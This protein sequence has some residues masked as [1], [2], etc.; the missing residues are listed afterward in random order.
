MYISIYYYRQDKQALNCKDNNNNNN[1]KNKDNNNNSNKKIPK[2]F[3]ESYHP[4][5]KRDQ[6]FIKLYENDSILVFV[7][8]HSFFLILSLIL[9]FSLILFHSHSFSFIL[10]HY[11]FRFQT[12]NQW[13]QLIS[14]NDMKSS[15]FGKEE[16]WR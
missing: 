12:Q 11:I 16:W 3:S 8:L 13:L 2:N 7:Y 5:M 10:S 1:N 15:P 4:T 9:S 6:Q 14:T